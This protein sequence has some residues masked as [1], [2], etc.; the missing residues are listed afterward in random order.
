MMSLKTFI[1]QVYD[2]LHNKNRTQ[3]D[4]INAVKVNLRR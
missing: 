2:S 1:E 3:A 4:L